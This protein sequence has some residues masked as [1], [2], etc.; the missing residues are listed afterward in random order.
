MLYIPVESLI[1][2]LKPY[3]PIIN[4]TM[5]DAFA[6]RG[7]ITITEDGVRYT[8][9]AGLITEHLLLTKKEAA[10]VQAVLLKQPNEEEPHV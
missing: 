10:Q 7:V 9:I 5:V 8:D 4:H 6:R 3:N 2:A 1:N